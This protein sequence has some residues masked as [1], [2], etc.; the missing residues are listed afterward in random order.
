MTPTPATPVTSFSEVNARDIAIAVEH[1][2][3]RP[4][5]WCS[6]QRPFHL[7][8]DTRLS[9]DDSECW[10]TLVFDMKHTSLMTVNNKTREVTVSRG[11]HCSVC[12]Q[13]LVQGGNARFLLGQGPRLRLRVLSWT[14]HIRILCASVGD[15]RPVDSQ[16]E[17][18]QDTV[19]EISHIGWWQGRFAPGVS[20]CW[21]S[22]GGWY[23]I[24]TNDGGQIV[25]PQG[26][27]SSVCLFQ[28]IDCQCFLN[29]GT[30][31]YEGQC[32]S[33]LAAVWL[34]SHLHPLLHHY[35]WPP[36]NW[37]FPSWPTVCLPINFG[38]MS[39]P[40]CGVVSTGWRGTPLFGWIIA[41]GRNKS[42]AMRCLTFCSIAF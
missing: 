37:M 29:E 7:K 40:T 19:V 20:W 24:G 2:P 42:S 17:T 15:A 31:V 1:Q 3:S 21:I 27:E 38:L 26:R 18:Y 8:V 34:N 6:L 5:D 4:H 35:D 23:I 11:G 33:V 39:P 16:M 14:G 9:L 41:S 30:A 32:N 10:Q 13:R 36:W 28:K 25:L 22:D 12:L